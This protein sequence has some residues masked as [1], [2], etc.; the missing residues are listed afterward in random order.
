MR[1]VVLQTQSV[2]SCVDHRSQRPVIG[3]QRMKVQ[4]GLCGV[5]LSKIRSRVRLSQGFARRNVGHQIV[6]YRFPLGE[7][8]IDVKTVHGSADPGRCDGIGSKVAVGGNLKH[9]STFRQ[10]PGPPAQALT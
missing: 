10:R 4:P 6:E 5:Q 9:D 2:I 1:C 8:P 3:V 7:A